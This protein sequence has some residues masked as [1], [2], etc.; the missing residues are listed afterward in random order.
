MRSFAVIKQ[1]PPLGHHGGAAAVGD[2]DGLPVGDGEEGGACT[3]ADPAGHGTP[4]RP[5]TCQL[6]NFR[7]TL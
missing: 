4:A 2:E 1:F 3:P 5:C 7:G 6:S